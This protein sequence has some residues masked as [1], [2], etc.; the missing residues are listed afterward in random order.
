MS[1]YINTNLLYIYV[2]LIRNHCSWDDKSMEDDR[3]C[4]TVTVL[5]TSTHG[6]LE[7]DAIRLVLIP[8]LL[9]SPVKGKKNPD[10]SCF[11]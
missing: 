2:L 5:E 10:S 7:L 11:V 3:F 8:F 6:S 9:D 4:I 1:V